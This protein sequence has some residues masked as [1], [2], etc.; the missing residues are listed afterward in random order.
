MDQLANF[1]L[2]RPEIRP[3]VQHS[4]LYVRSAPAVIKSIL[5]CKLP[6][7]V[8]P[9]DVDDDDDDEECDVHQMRKEFSVAPVRHKGNTQREAKNA[10]KAA[11]SMID[12]Q[13][14]KALGVAIP[15][16]RA[17]GDEVVIRVLGVLRGFFEVRPL[18]S[19]G[20]LDQRSPA[21]LFGLY[22]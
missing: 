15:V 10:R 5:D 19:I 9:K 14:F 2:L 3:L 11:K 7:K 8:T 6:L 18:C 20:Y 22:S 4:Q 16:T 12:P 21:E 13:P 1:L 17:Q